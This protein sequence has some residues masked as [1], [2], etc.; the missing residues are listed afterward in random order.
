MGFK[1]NQGISVTKYPLIV[2]QRSV[3]QL[4]WG[5]PI[6]TTLI[7]LALLRSPPYRF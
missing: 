3:R 7:V 4:A 6:Y 2:S 1:A 5:N